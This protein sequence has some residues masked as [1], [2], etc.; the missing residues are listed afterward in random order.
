MFA[1]RIRQHQQQVIRCHQYDAPAP[2]T[3]H[4][5]SPIRRSSSSNRSSNVTN[6]MLQLQ[7]QVI[8][9]HQYDAP[10]PVT[11]YP[12]SP[13]VNPKRGLFW[14]S[15]CTTSLMM[16]K[17]LFDDELP[18]FPS[19]P[20][21]SRVIADFVTL[22]VT[23]HVDLSGTCVV[24]LLPIDSMI[25]AVTLVATIWLSGHPRSDNEA[26]RSPS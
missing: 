11:G 21:I 26:Q 24:Y 15:Q 2:A 3:G 10:A 13:T 1:F 18:T 22:H 19:K 9:P 12:A 4:P 23:P 8:Q 14:A 6:T 20:V 5:V 16:M 7:Q 17:M 25:S